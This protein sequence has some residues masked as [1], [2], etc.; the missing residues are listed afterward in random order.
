[1][2]W[3]IFKSSTILPVVLFS[4]FGRARKTGRKNGE[5]ARLRTNFWNGANGSRHR[6]HSLAPRD[7]M[8]RLTREPGPDRV[9]LTLRQRTVRRVR[10]ERDFLPQLA[11]SLNS[12]R[13]GFLGQSKV[14]VSTTFLRKL[15]TC[16][17]RAD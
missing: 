11:N 15:S 13:T 2:E 16:Q 5:S 9:P 8:F 12:L 6:S 3:S 4:V 17:T 14:S 1:M 10:I 7:L